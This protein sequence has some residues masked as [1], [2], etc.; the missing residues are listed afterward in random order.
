MWLSSWKGAPITEWHLWGWLLQLPVPGTRKQGQCLELERSIVWQL[1][2]ALTL[3]SGLK[4]CPPPCPSSAPRAIGGL[5]QFV[6]TVFSSPWIFVFSFPV[7]KLCMCYFI[8]M[9]PFWTFAFAGQ[10]HIFL[11]PLVLLK[12]KN[13]FGSCALFTKQKEKKKEE[14]KVKYCERK[15][16]T[17]LNIFWINIWY[18]F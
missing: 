9:V 13:T 1:L 14:K 4:E 12:L 18:F 2:A 8:P 6:L 7:F 17:Q 16:K 10:L 15:K 11:K 5:E 3:T